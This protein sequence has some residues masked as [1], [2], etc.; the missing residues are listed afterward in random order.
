MATIRGYL[1]K[2]M[3]ID[4]SLLQ[5]INFMDHCLRQYPSENHIQVKR[6]WFPHGGERRPLNEFAVS[7]EAQKGV[8]ASVR[9]CE[10]PRFNTASTGLGVNVDV[11]NGVFWVPQQVHQ[12]ARNLLAS[13]NPNLNW[14]DFTRQLLPRQRSQTASGTPIY[15]QSPQFK[16]LRKMQRLKFFVK[17]R[18][19]EQNAKIY[20]IDHFAWD[21]SYGADGGNAK[22]V[23]FDRRSKT[24]PNAPPVTTSIFDY[25]RTE[26]NIDIECWRLPLV[27]SKKGG[28][29]PMEVCTL[30]EDQRYMFKLD[31]KQTADMIKFAV[32]R[33]PA[34]LA[35]IQ[36]G[37][38]LLAWETDPYLKHYG[39]KIDPNPTVTNAKL[40]Q[41][42]DIQFGTGGAKKVIRPETSGSWILAGTHLHQLPKRPLEWWHVVF[43]DGT[44]KYCGWDKFFIT[45]K[46]EYKNLG[47]KAII[48]DPSCWY[49]NQTQLETEIDNL[50]STFRNVQKLPQWPQII[51]FVVKDRNSWVYDRIKKIMD[52]KYA[53]Y[54]QVMQSA[55]ISKNNKKYASNV[56]LKVNAKLGGTTSRA[57]RR[58]EGRPI[59]TL[60][61]MDPITKRRPQIFPAP[62]YLNVNPDKGLLAMI[63]GA[64]VSHPAASS[65]QPS[66]AAVTMSMDHYACRYTAVTEVNGINVEMIQKPVWDGKVKNMANHW[67]RTVGTINGTPTVPHHLYYIRDGVSEGQYMQ[68]LEQEVR[69]LRNMLIEGVSPKFSMTK[70]TVIIASKRHHLRFLPDKNDRCQDSEGNPF[71][72]VLVEHDITHPYQFDFYLNAHKAIQGT[73]RPVHYH[74]IKDEINH[75]PD[76]LHDILYAHS[77]QYMRSTTPVSLHPAVYYAHL[78][79]KRG[80]AHENEQIVQY[81]RGGSQAV[82]QNTNAKYHADRKEA[83]RSQ[84][85]EGQQRGSSKKSSEKPDVKLVPNIPIGDYWRSNAPRDLLDKHYKDRILDFQFG[86][87]FI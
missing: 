63:I 66:F 41:P 69:W 25:F 28:I 43:L 24:N 50:M 37:V 30:L 77:Y 31:P 57:I 53:V 45:L 18:G 67:L 9:M 74:V 16:D 11:A 79:S 62:N 29:F 85:Q 70:F 17:H 52:T 68:V 61:P 21:Q 8:Y 27:A 22:R 82:Q 76:F 84:A 80:T 54:T 32:V 42:P 6:S 81:P 86:M 38:K 19:K 72:G 40:L 46:E 78:A 71:P 23:T 2:T 73:S 48:S 58:V 49:W 44:Q 65:N 34:R 15:E 5:A 4:S 51:V 10:A 1:E 60:G 47:N 56:L 75:S 36:T 35:S 59:T 39:I 13:T 3:E 14:H 20:S 7:I 33:P 64:D 83:L 12:A 26:Y 87:W 55:Q